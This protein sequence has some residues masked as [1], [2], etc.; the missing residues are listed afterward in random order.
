M[1]SKTSVKASSSN[2]SASRGA[3]PGVWRASEGT[4]RPSTVRKRVMAMQRLLS[5]IQIQWLR[6][7]N[8]PGAPSDAARREY[9]LSLNIEQ[10]DREAY[11]DA[12]KALNRKGLAVVR[13]LPSEAGGR[14][15][16]SWR[17]DDIPAMRRFGGLDPKKGGGGR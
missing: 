14:A 1:N 2:T 17:P 7:K 10:C 8:R 6:E 3:D 9:L 16:L 5:N 13:K 4:N 15:E 12:I 11:A